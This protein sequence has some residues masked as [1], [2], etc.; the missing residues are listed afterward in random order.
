MNLTKNEGV[1]FS[2]CT[3]VTNREKTIERT[4]LSIKKQTCNNYEYIIYNNCSE[5][6]SDEV[7]RNFLKLYPDFDQKV[8]YIVGRER[9]ADIASWNAPLKHT[10]G[11]YVVVCEGDDWFDEQYLEKAYDYL[12]VNDSVGI[13]VA[14]KQKHNIRNNVY[15]KYLNKSPSYMKKEL[16]MFN[17]VPPPSEAIFIREKGGVPFLYDEHLVYA[18]EYS[19]YYKILNS[20]FSTYIYQ[21]KMIYRGASVK[22]KIKGYFHVKDAYYCMNTLWNDDY[23]SKD[24]YH[25]SSKLLVM[26]LSLLGQQI[27]NLRFE[28]EMITHCIKEMVRLKYYPVS[29]VFKGIYWAS[30]KRLR[31][32]KRIIIGRKH[33][34]IG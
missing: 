3:E 22:R 29:F 5:D 10:T 21:E 25:A 16:M 13:F 7:I 14:L 31:Y 34:K 2:I 24:L 8:K 23:N 1:F 6:N 12:S 18:G 27:A 33:E 9:L 4:L 28:S 19:L 11:K 32:L 15:S 17:F 26:S 20:G 30:M